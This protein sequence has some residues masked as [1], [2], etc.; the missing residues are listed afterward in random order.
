MYYIIYTNTP[1]GHLII[2]SIML[3]KEKSM[4]GLRKQIM[5]W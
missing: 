5:R 3:K 2:I 1:T 4:R